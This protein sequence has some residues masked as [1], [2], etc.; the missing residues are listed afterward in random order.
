MKVLRNLAILAV[1]GWLGWSYL[2]KTEPGDQ[3][4]VVISNGPVHIESMPDKQRRRGTF[5]KSKFSLDRSWYFRH[6]AQGPTH[7]DV[8]VSNS[9]CGPEARYDTTELRVLSN[10]VGM[11]QTVTISVG[12]FLSMTALELDPGDSTITR[13]ERMP[14]QLVIGRSEDQLTSV[15]I[16]RSTCAFNAGE[17]SITIT[18]KR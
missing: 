10:G 4:P 2:T 16:E 17:G 1:L 12:G 3:P 13:D 15:T 6:P 7:F 14:Y 8:L 11:S 18:P 5:E 9:T